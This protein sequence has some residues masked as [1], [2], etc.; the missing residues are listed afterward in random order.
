[1]FY[2]LSLAL[3]TIVLFTAVKVVGSVIKG[4][5]YGVA[6]SLLMSVVY[7]FVRSYYEPV[8]VFDTFMIDNF[9]VSRIL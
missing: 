7:L 4:M 8:V 3:F 2:I 6:V 1:M 9:E 5:L